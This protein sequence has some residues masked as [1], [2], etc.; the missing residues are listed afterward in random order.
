KGKT[1]A[2]WRILEDD[3]AILL[4]TNNGLFRLGRDGKA[5]RLGKRYDITAGFSILRSRAGGLWVAVSNALFLI[6]PGGK[7]HRFNARPASSGGFSARIVMDLFEDADGGI[8][9]STLYNGL[10]YLSPNWRDFSRFVHVPG[11]SQG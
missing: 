7:V 8:W 6:E 2:V 11:M 5:E 9:L 3:G 4:A 1:R 10:L